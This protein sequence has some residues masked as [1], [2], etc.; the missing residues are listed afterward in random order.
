MNTFNKEKFKRAKIF[1]QFIKH[2]SEELCMTLHIEG[3]IIGYTTDGGFAIRVTEYDDSYFEF[4]VDGKM[5]LYRTEED[6]MLA[7]CQ[8]TPKKECEEC[9]GDKHLHNVSCGFRDDIRI[10]NYL[11]V[12]PDIIEVGWEEDPE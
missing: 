10:K 6:A 12:K 8:A 3:R 9:L 1:S 11:E 4:V 7:I 2:M 5:P